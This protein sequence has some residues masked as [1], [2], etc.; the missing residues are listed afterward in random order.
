MGG[1]LSLLAGSAAI[2]LGLCDAIN[3]WFLAP[4]GLQVS[5]DVV[6]YPTLRDFDTVH[7]LELFLLAAVGFPVIFGVSFVLLDRIVP[8]L[9]ER[10]DS[11]AL[12]NG[13]GVAA[14]L[15]IPARCSGWR[16]PSS[17]TPPAAGR[18]PPTA[19]GAATYAAVAPSSPRLVGRRA[20]AAVPAP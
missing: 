6:G 12:V 15:A 7:Y 14:R 19:L 5:T 10:L 11:P 17:P 3:H 13:S 1:I 8:R 4:G 9:L 16:G 18:S 2:A 20:A